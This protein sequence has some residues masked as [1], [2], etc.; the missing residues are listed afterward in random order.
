MLRK[1]A[2]KLAQAEPAQVKNIQYLHGRFFKVKVRHT[3]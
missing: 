1:A 3:V 2:A